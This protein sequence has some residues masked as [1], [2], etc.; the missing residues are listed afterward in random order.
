MTGPLT[1]TGAQGASRFEVVGKSPM[2]MSEGFCYGNMG[3]YWGPALKRAGFDGL[4]VSGKASRPVYLFISDGKAAL[5][6]ASE[7]HLEGVTQVREYLQQK[8]GKKTHFITTGPAGMNRCRTANLMTDNEG[9]ATGGFGAVLG[10]KNLKAI[11]VT[12]TQSPP[13]SDPATLNKLNR[14]TIKLNQRDTTFNPFPPDQ[15]FRKGKAS[16]FRKK[17]DADDTIPTIMPNEIEPVYA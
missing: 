14:L 12:G 15:I 7:I 10:A 3:G 9:S 17:A 11:A 4:M 5:K 1:A 13:V 2:L 6:E 16:C 8:H